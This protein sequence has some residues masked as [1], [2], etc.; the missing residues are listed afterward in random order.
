MKNLILLASGT[1]E[2]YIKLLNDNPNAAMVVALG[3]LCLT[4]II[5]QFIKKS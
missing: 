4:L 5:V 3:M 1:P 2:D